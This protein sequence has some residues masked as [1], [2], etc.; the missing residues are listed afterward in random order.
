MATERLR[1]PHQRT[2]R[3]AHDWAERWL[4][5][6]GI[7]GKA[8]RVLLYMEAQ[9]SSAERDAQSRF[10]E[11]VLNVLALAPTLDEAFRAV[12]EL[13]ARIEKGGPL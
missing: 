6:Q 12:T 5:D 11:E 1:K 13:R 3:E 8:A 9:V 4:S 10:A 7:V 2:I